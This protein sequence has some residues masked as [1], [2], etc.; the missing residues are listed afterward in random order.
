MIEA[1]IEVTEVTPPVL[2]GHVTVGD[3]TYPFSLA[4]D[5]EKI[6]TRDTRR[7]FQKDE[8]KEMATR[9]VNKERFV[10]AAMGVEEHDFESDFVEAF[11][12]YS[13]ACRESLKR[14]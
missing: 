11:S 4:F 10:L 14:K 1:R 12:P 8:F 5:G 7:R 2:K 6:L 3:K 9:W 13:K